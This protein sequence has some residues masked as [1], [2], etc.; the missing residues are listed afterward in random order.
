MDQ[1][2][3]ILCVDDEKIVLDSLRAQLRQ[4]FKS[5]Y[6][7]ETAESGDEGLEIL[8]EFHKGVVKSL[9]QEQSGIQDGMD[10]SICVYDE[11]AEQLMY[12][13]AKRPLVY[14]KNGQME[15]VKGG[16]LP[17]GGLT[18]YERVYSNHVVQIDT[19]TTCYI[20][21]DGFV[22]QHGGEDNTRF[23]IKTFRDLIFK[24]SDKP[25]LE[26]QKRLEE[27]MI[28]WQGEHPQTDDMLVIGF[29][30]SPN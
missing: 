3:Y 5:D 10:A 19:E 14:V 24:N 25:L 13:G 12:A 7:I 23:K 28:N 17:I 8:E 20:F 4:F 2:E 11:D 26:Q 16:S 18:E 9:N 1:R 30:I 27:T 15:Y 6:I 22:D 21:S 29:K